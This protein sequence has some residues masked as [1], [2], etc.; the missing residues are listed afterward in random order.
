LELKL[1]T[2]QFSTRS[3]CKVAEA[4]DQLIV[5]AIGILGRRLKQRDVF[6]TP[7]A[8]KDFLRLKARSLDY[9]IFA[10][11]FIDAQNQLIEYEQLFRGTLTQTSVYPREVLKQSLMH[12][13]AS[14]ILHHNHPSGRCEPSRSDE[15]LT[16]TLRSALALVDVRVLDHIITSDEGALSMAER[17]LL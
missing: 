3:Y 13:A 14:V 7:D 10:V 15:L 12:G 11:M 4:E 9:E 2:S 1:S 17:G 5:K 16:Q 8:V 6:S